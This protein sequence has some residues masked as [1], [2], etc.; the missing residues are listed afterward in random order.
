MGLPISFDIDICVISSCYGPLQLI[1]INYQKLCPSEH[2]F[3]WLLMSYDACSFLNVFLESIHWMFLLFFRF[4]L[5]SSNSTMI[6]LRTSDMSHL[7]FLIHPIFLVSHTYSEKPNF[8]TFAIFLLQHVH[9]PFLP[10]VNCYIAASS[11][12]TTATT[13]KCHWFHNRGH[14][15]SAPCCPPPTNL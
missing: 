11:S 8:L 3:W 14:L 13:Y 4:L 7:N 5:Q 15:P 10:T 2:I 12:T 9:L 6:W 1:I